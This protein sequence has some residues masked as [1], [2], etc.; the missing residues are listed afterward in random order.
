[1]TKEK[2][3]KSL[4]LSIRTAKV[5]QKSGMAKPDTK[6]RVQGLIEG[7]KYAIELLKSK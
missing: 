1:M 4:Q 3:I 6:I 7:Y 5:F 2:I